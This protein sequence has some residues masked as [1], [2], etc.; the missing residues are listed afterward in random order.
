MR[1]ARMFGVFGKFNELFVL[2]AVHATMPHGIRE[3]DRTARGFF[4]GNHAVGQDD[5]VRLQARQQR[6]RHLLRQ[7]KKFAADLI[8][9]SCNR[10]RY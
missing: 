1:V 9:R 6:I 7:P 4:G 3:R 8:G 5:I 2:D 10:V